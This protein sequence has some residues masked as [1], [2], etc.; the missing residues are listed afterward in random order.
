MLEVACLGASVVKNPVALGE[1]HHWFTAAAAAR[2][3]FVAG[4]ANFV[5]AALVLAAGAAEHPAVQFAKGP[6]QFPLVVFKVQVLIQ[7]H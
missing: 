2:R 4:L 5:P 6:Q 1:A 7:T 3:I